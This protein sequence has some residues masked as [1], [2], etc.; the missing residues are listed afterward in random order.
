[1]ITLALTV[2]YQ[3]ELVWSIPDSVSEDYQR[4]GN[5]VDGL[6]GIDPK[7]APTTTP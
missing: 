1:M 5:T 6:L 2:R 7:A 3:G 4:M